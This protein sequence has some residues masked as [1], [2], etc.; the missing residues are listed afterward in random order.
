MLIIVTGQ[1]FEEKMYQEMHPYWAISIDSNKINNSLLRRR[2]CHVLLS[3]PIKVTGRRLKK[4]NSEKKGTLSFLAVQNSSIG[5]LVTHSLT[6]SLRVLLLL[7]YK[8][9][10]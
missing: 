3:D 8:E 1:S 10:P 5:D 9:R 6:E 7:T 2:D 4:K